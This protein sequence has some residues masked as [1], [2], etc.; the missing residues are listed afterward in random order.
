VCP[1][2]PESQG[3]GR[4]M[5]Y[6]QDS[7]GGRGWCVRRPDA[8]KDSGGEAAAGH[9]TRNPERAGCVH[10][11]RFQRARK[12]RPPLRIWEME[13]R[14]TSKFLPRIYILTKN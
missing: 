5:G 12:I 11:G 9:Q 3:G 2:D 6:H 10:G 1:E 7:E 4:V 14:L 8:A 13:W